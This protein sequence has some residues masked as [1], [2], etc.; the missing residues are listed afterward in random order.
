MHRNTAGAYA[1]TFFHC[2]ISHEAEDSDEEDEAEEDEEA[3]AALKA[4]LCLRLFAALRLS[5]WAL[6]E[7]VSSKDRFGVGK[8]S[9]VKLAWAV[10]FRVIALMSPASGPTCSQERGLS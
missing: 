5:C 1:Q 9:V 6:A 4:L 7:S 2:N 8:D 10:C 3:L